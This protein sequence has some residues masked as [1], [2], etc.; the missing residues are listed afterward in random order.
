[1]L[2]RVLRQSEQDP[3]HSS[4]MLAT[5]SDKNNKNRKG[6]PKTN[7]YT[8]IMKDHKLANIDTSQIDDLRIS[9]DETY[10]ERLF[11][12]KNYPAREKK[13]NHGDSV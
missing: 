3:A 8:E 6:R 1:M 2:G 7:L 11:E 5:F 12:H 10:W 4:L 13:I 9:R